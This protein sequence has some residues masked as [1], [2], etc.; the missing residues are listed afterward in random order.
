METQQSVRPSSPPRP[1]ATANTSPVDGHQGAGRAQSHDGGPSGG[2][3]A[4]QPQ[5]LLGRSDTRGSNGL[6]GR[7]KAGGQSAAAVFGH[8]RQNNSVIRDGAARRK[9]GGQP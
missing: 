3:R 4:L 7:L 6:M 5:G 2:F 9:H 8:G 1:P